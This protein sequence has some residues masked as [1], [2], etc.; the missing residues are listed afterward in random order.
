MGRTGLLVVCALLGGCAIGI[1]RSDSGS[2]SIY[3]FGFGRVQVSSTEGE[4]QL[5]AYRMNV[6]GAAYAQGPHP[7]LVVGVGSA[8]AIYADA[9][10][11]DGHLDISYNWVSQLEVA[12]FKPCTEDHESLSLG[13]EQ[14]V[15]SNSP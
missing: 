15:I 6:A 4:S 12:T 3:V 7:S 8:S 13:R 9:Q 10:C 2:K 1:D 5:G 11:A 14:D